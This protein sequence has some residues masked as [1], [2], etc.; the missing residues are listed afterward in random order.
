MELVRSS[1]SNIISPIQQRLRNALTINKESILS[2]IDAR[3]IAPYIYFILFTLAAVLLFVKRLPQKKHEEI[4]ETPQNRE[5]YKEIALEQGLIEKS[6]ELKKYA[7]NNWFMK[8]QTDWNYFNAGLENGKKTWFDAKE[9]EWQK[10]LE[11]MEDR[12]A[13]YN[14][15]MDTEFKSDILKNAQDW[16]ENQWETWMKDEGEKIM[17]MHYHK[18]IDGSYAH[19]NAWI[20]KKWEEWKNEKILTWLLK[21]WRRKEFDYWQ[22]Y[23]DLTLPEPLYERAQSN[24]NKWNNRL[25]NEKE[26]W[27]KWVAE[28]YEFYENSECKQWKK[29]KDG[30]EVLFNEWRESYM[31]KL[32]AGKKWKVWI[33]EKKNETACGA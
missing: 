19:Y 20:I 24:W 16:D 11:S 4:P 17:E 1:Y 7:W 31:C 14:E 33:E 27:K 22:K 21:D 26:Q 2:N 28:K 9:K 18:W 5:L 8:L 6:E 13:H 12:W 15:N 10:W 30:R 25:C 29:W 23:K 32:V 3:S